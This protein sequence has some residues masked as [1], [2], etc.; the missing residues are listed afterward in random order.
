MSEVNGNRVEIKK[1]LARAYTE[2]E[3]NTSS[4]RGICSREQS[5]ESSLGARSGEESEEYVP[6]ISL[7]D[8][9]D[10]DDDK[11]TISEKSRAKN[12]KR[13][14]RA[15]SHQSSDE[16]AVALND[17]NVTSIWKERIS[18]LI[19]DPDDD[20]YAITRMVESR[21]FGES[22]LP[23]KLNKRIW[24]R[25]HDFQQ[26]GVE[27]MQKKTDQRSGGILADE[28]GLGKTVQTVAYLRSLSETGRTY[29]KWNGLHS[30]L[31][32]A[33][34]SILHQWIQT[35]N[36]WFPKVRVFLVHSHSTSGN[37]PDYAQR[38][39]KK[40]IEAKNKHYPDGCVVLT[41]YNGFTKLHNLFV[42]HEWQVVFLD[43]GHY[44]R[45]ENTQCSKAMRK[46]KTPQRFILSGTPF[47]N[48]LAEF[49]KL[50]DFVH[51]GRLSDAN[52]FHRN[53]TN[54]INAGASL[55][56]SPQA[57]A[58]AYECLV[59]LQHAI[60]PMILRRLQV[61][62]KD[63]LNL[64]EKNEMVI[65][66]EL[67]KRQ[68]RLY[69]EYCNSS[70]VAEIIERRVK[71]FI[72]FNKLG[73]I[74]NHPGIYRNAEPNSRKFGEIE[75]SGKV[76]MLFK[77][78]AE[79]FKSPKNRVIL[80]TQR[81]NVIIMMQHF[82]DQKKIRHVALTGSV[83]ASSRPKI[84]KKFEDDLDI[85]VFLMTTRA[86]GLGLNLTS[87][88]R[89]VI[90]DP[91][92]NPQAD[93]QAKNRIYRM[94][95]EHNVS[96]IRLISNGTLEDRKLLKQVQKETLAA[97]LLNNADTAHIVPN[98]T[99]HDLFRLTPQGLEGSEIGKN[100]LAGFEDKKLLLSLFDDEKLV[101]MRE[102]SITVQ[103]SSSMNRIERQNMRAA[104]DEA[105]GSLI[106]SE[107]RLTHTWKNEFHKLLRESTKK[108]VVSDYFVEEEKVDSYWNA[109][110][111]HIKPNDDK[112]E[113]SNLLKVAKKM[114]HLLNGIDKAEE[115]FIYRVLVTNRDRED[116][117]QMFFVREILSTIAK[118]D[119]ES[120]TWRIRSKYRGMEIMEP[121]SRKRTSVSQL[122][123]I[124]R[125]SMKRQ[126]EDGSG[127]R[128][129]TSRN[130]NSEDEKRKS[131]TRC[132]SMPPTRISSKFRTSNS[133][134]K[135][136]GKRQYG[137]C[138]PSTPPTSSMLKL[139]DSKSA[140]PESKTRKS[141]P[142]SASV[143]PNTYS[144][145]SRTT[146]AAES[147]DKERKLRSPFSK[148]PT[149]SSSNNDDSKNIESEKR[150]RKSVSRSRS[151]PREMMETEATEDSGSPVTK[152]SPS[153]KDRT[154]KTTQPKN[155]KR[156]LASRSPDAP[157]KLKKSDSTENV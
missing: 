103:N 111:S 143:H 100:R 26:E 107:N 96:I 109:V 87:A 67:S 59:A 3:P 149:T 134:E 41:T 99:L 127:P 116:A 17:D 97:Q 146:K 50:V 145:K 10:N 151:V 65:S 55:T 4:P 47:Q 70:E 49:W 37:K 82:L 115:S 33:H 64:P 25:L 105:V 16:D 142:R 130:T 94:G 13:Q 57:A 42:S 72:G 61:D 153:S 44:I 11:Q 8:D 77:L 135:D 108:P 138:P 68:R 104:V 62:H 39:F 18:N 106:H 60:K 114:L 79:W 34:V 15:S 150:N 24:E 52:T 85:K 128:V 54:I 21:E 144:Y 51:P 30:A 74:C 139:R 73:D 40:L 43:E 141:L 157:R 113:L 6:G 81:K 132:S 38:I 91:D 2:D 76:A 117:T 152:E 53:F 89:V 66:C 156:K 27:W 46:L 28:M 19:V 80:F 22:D 48:R 137:S 56:C 123:S 140:E 31:I 119:F 126:T 121:E 125:K 88:N 136:D 112:M 83:T 29:F 147:K 5:T 35:L 78:F 36:E 9:D 92:W 12:K 84:I 71:P 131:D 101:A 90:F 93:N 75:D 23:W 124:P 129:S 102:H 110:H 133:V 63:V 86:G 58:V 14:R 7:S 20:C 69:E 98:N 120:N 45:N 122:P 1:S 95:Q 154:T 118:F 148:S 155:G 32:V